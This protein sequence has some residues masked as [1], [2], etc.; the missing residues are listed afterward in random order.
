MHR[1]CIPDVSG[2]RRIFFDVILVIIRALCS[3]G[4][5]SAVV[6]PACC[7]RDGSRRAAMDSQLVQEQA[8]FAPDPLVQKKSKKN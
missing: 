4:R 1:E 3:Q 6:V 8:Y 2:A 7:A 5:R